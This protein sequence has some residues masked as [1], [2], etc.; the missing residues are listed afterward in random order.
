MRSPPLADIKVH[1]HPWP[2]NFKAVEAR[3]LQVG[4]NVQL[5]GVCMFTRVTEIFELPSGKIYVAT[6]MRVEHLDLSFLCLVEA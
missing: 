4:D 1:G 5:P 6:P 3:I 2:S